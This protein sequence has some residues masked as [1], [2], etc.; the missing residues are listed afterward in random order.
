VAGVR[1]AI[2]VCPRQETHP[3]HARRGACHCGG[4]PADRASGR[5][6]SRKPGGINSN[7]EAGW[8]GQA[9][10]RFLAAAIE[11]PPQGETASGWLRSEAERIEAITVER[12]DTVYENQWVP[13]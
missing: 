10:L 1:H 4:I 9:R 12:W 3:L 7:L 2:P 5:R 11:V 6:I 8:D 13:D